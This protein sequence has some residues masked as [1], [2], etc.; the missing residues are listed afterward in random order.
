[1]LKISPG[2]PTTTRD[3]R[4]CFFLF[5]R[6]NSRPGTA[7]LEQPGSSRKSEMEQ[8]GAKVTSRGE[9]ATSLTCMLLW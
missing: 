9:V 5:F 4:Q 2:L 1:M 8:P 6:S 7:E 3:K